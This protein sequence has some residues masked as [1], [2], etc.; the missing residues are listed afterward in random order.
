MMGLRLPVW[1]RLFQRTAPHLRLGR[2]A[3]RLAARHLKGQGYRVRARNL[4]TALGEIDLLAE[5]PDGR[6]IVVVEVKAAAGCGD[7]AK[8]AE[9][10]PEGHV[11]AIKQRRLAALAAAAVRRFGLQDRPLRFD[12]VAVVVPPRGTAIVRHW[13]GA[14]V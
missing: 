8:D 13:S 3:E 12:V 2:R 9:L 14:F 1:T 11:T 5:A 4:R 10:R 6:T 7:A